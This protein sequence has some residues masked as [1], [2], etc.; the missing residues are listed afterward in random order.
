MEQLI[1]KKLGLGLR[2]IK[3]ILK[4]KKLCKRILSE[5]VLAITTASEI[6]GLTKGLILKL[7][8]SGVIS[9]FGNSN[10]SKGSKMFVFLKELELYRKPDYSSMAIWLDIKRTI[11]LYIPLI[12]NLTQEEQ[13]LLQSIPD[14]TTNRLNTQ[15]LRKK[16]SIIFDKVLKLSV[17]LPDIVYLEAY[18]EKLKTTIEHLEQRVHI[19]QRVQAITAEQLQGEL[20]LMTPIRDIGLNLR[21]YNVVR[22]FDTLGELVAYT[23][24]QISKFRNCGAKTLQD[25]TLKLQSY[26]LW[27]GYYSL[28]KPF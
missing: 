1:A 15:T 12:P 28:P 3:N 2:S 27:L 14:Q 9:S 25:I 18:K 7:A 11:Q 20:A 24:A 22:A 17:V 8:K 6:T 19:E 26:D 4:N 21:A 5:E 23:P 10:W 13:Q 16:Q